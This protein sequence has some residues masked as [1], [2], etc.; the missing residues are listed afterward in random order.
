FQPRQYRRGQR[1]GQDHRARAPHQHRR[2]DR[3]AP[4]WRAVFLP[5]A[6]WWM[7]AMPRDSRWTWIA[8]A[9]PI[10][11]Q[12]RPDVVTNLLRNLDAS[13]KKGTAV[14]AAIPFG[15]KPLLKSRR[16]DTVRT[17]YR[18]RPGLGSWDAASFVSR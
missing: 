18:R 13:T 9:S 12:R 16:Q 14:F 1:A 8:L 2:T 15:F 5:A 3:S 7:L 17:F 4:A 11:P 6:V 10:L